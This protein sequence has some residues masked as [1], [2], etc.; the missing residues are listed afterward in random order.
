MA[1]PTFPRK[2]NYNLIYL[3]TNE[4]FLI[5]DAVQQWTPKQVT[6]WQ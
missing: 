5:S 4:I 3:L 2:Q 6:K 1:S